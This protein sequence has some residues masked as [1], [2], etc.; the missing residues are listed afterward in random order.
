M[1]RRIELEYVLPLAWSAETS[2]REA[3]RLGCYL[4]L[5]A[6]TV[7]VTVVDGSADDVFDRHH[8]QWSGAVR[9]VRPAPRPGANGKVAGVVT[10]VQL[11]RHDR[12]ILADDDVRYDAAA[13]ALM[14]RALETADVIRPQCVYGSESWCARWDSARILIN[15]SLGH[16]YPGTYG[17]RRTI[18]LEAGGYDGDA[19]F[20]NLEMVRTL[21]VAGARLSNRPELFVRRTPPAPE[22]FLSQRV[23]QA[24]DSFAQPVR[25]A[26]E[27]ALLPAFALSIGKRPRLVALWAVAPVVVAEIGRR[28]HRGRSVFAWTCSLWGPVWVAERAVSVWLAVWQRLRGGVRYRGRRVRLAAHSTAQLRARRVDPRMGSER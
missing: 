6:E 28:R 26:A 4:R 19:L 13:L 12:V 2:A 8:D 24:Y 5:L 3:D 7:D 18:F 23:R 27:C 11:A 16:D 15:R 9:H 22:Q 21:V 25:L 17:V 14:A 1:A 20:E 10:G